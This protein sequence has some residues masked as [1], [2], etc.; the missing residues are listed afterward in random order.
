M[1][2]LKIKNN[3]L[4]INKNRKLELASDSEISLQRIYLSLALLQGDFFYDVN[5]GIPYYDL[6][7]EQTNNE[8][9]SLIVYIID[10]LYKLSFVEKVYS[11]NVDID[12]K[13][14][15][16]VISGVIVDVYGKTILLQNNNLNII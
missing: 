6:L 11:I 2:D 1:I 4:I 3:D 10:Y 5:Q 13:S 16:L 9:S 15:T 14:R 8:K 12:S 7:S